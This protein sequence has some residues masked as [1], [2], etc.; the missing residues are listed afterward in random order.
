MGSSCNRVYRLP[1]D[2]YEMTYDSQRGSGDMIVQMEW[3]SNEQWPEHMKADWGT[4]QL[5]YRCVGA[6]LECRYM[7]NAPI[8]FVQQRKQRQRGCGQYVPWPY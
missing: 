8:N 1:Y 5:P 6:Q 4:K 7:L 3:W 2:W